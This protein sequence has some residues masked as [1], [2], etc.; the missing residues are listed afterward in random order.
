M[1]KSG[2]VSALDR[3]GA[4]GGAEQSSHRRT[5]Q[6]VHTRLRQAILDGEVEPG[7]PISQLALS[8]QLRVSRG[9]LREALRMLE[10][11][12]LVESE[13][14]RRMRVTG[15]SMSDLEELYA[16]RIALEV[17]A[18][19]MSTLAM[20]ETHLESLEAM[21]REIEAAAEER[22]HSAW[23]GPH[24]EFHRLLISPSGPRVTGAAE[25]LSDH[26]ERYRQFYASR[27]PGA[28]LD[29][30]PDHREIFEAIR[31]RAPGVAASCL[32]RHYSAVV[33]ALMARLDPERDPAAIRSA[34]R[35][36]AAYRD[37]GEE[38]SAREGS[39][40]VRVSR[41]A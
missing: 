3:T 36:A 8:R 11:E 9:P 12:G 29:G 28:W 6:L 20:D 27:A 40:A 35:M 21:V 37:L 10:H 2:D 5:Q 34:V 41:D 7:A 18:I 30:V 4:R 15:F 38:V 19:S 16:M 23:I 1:T 32:A 24:R 25:E 31:D 13:P 39:T 17:L 22:D 33:L 14:N 26:A